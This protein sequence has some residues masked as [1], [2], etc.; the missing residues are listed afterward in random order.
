MGSPGRRKQKERDLERVPAAGGRARTS[1]PR[2]PRDAGRRPRAGC[3][4]GRPSG[5]G[6]GSGAG[7]HVE[8]QSGAAC[9]PAAFW[10]RDPASTL[11]AAAFGRGAAVWRGGAAGAA[12]AGSGGPASQRVPAKA[13]GW[14]RQ[15][16]GALSWGFHR[17]GTELGQR[18]RAGQ[19]PSRG[20][21]SAPLAGASRVPGGRGRGEDKSPVRLPWRLP[22]AL[23]IP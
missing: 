19:G 13:V 21:A 23:L 18:P 6:R 8:A 17:S 9:A 16:A 15:V 2:P 5:R 22:P 7:A 3:P 11:E 20:P 1:G 12:G 4:R 14:A 10:Q